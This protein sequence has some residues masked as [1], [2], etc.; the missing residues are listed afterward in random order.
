MRL[1][2]ATKHGDFGDGERSVE[3]SH[4]LLAVGRV[5]NTDA[6]HLERAGIEV[7]EHGFLQ[8]D[9]WLE[10]TVGG[11]YGIGDVKGGPE[12]THISYDDYRVL[13]ANLLD[14]AYR[15]TKGRPI[16]YTMFLDPELGRIGMTETEAR[17]AGR[18]IKIAKMPMTSVARGFESGETRGFLKA[19]VDAKTDQILGAACL[20][21]NG[22][23][24]AA[25]LQIAMMG[26]VTASELRDCIWS[27][28]TWAE[29]LN[30][31]FSKYE[32]S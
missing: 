22:G 17:K 14:N 10:T 11:V 5:P 31:L 27:H 12:F 1:T 7:D 4:L 25:M 29:A 21:V 32:E 26:Q 13:K 24:Y 2:L 15:S 19:I 9:E 28:P 16:P 6:L 3:G 20:G 23:E 18:S 8:V 30:N